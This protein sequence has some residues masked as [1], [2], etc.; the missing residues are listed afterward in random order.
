V[1][2]PRKLDAHLT[3]WRRCSRVTRHP[4]GVGEWASGRSREQDSL[5]GRTREKDIGKGH[6]RPT[7]ARLLHSVLAGPLWSRVCA[8]GA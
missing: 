8:M 6:L 7:H 3:A 1:R 2:L 4:G 5:N